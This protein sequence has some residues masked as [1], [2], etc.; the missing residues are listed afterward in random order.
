[1]AATLLSPSHLRSRCFLPKGCGCRLSAARSHHELFL[2]SALPAGLAPAKMSPP[3]IGW[4]DYVWYQSYLG[5]VLYSIPIL[6]QYGLTIRRLKV[7]CR[8]SD[9]D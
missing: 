7:V 1:M 6:W 2:Q 4:A 3:N 8:D 9:P 5:K